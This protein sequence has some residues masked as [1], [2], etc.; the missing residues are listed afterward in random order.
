MIM[1]KSAYPHTR[2]SSR[3]S[4]R[5]SSKLSLSYFHIPDCSLI[6]LRIP[7][8]TSAPANPAS[9]AISFIRIRSFWVIQTSLLQK[10]VR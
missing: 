7:S 9:T 2:Y 5:L 8:L 10:S 6:R 4:F 3:L 1:G